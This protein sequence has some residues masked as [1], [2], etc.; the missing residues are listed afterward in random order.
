MLAMKAMFERRILL[1]IGLAFIIDSVVTAPAHAQRADDPVAFV[2]SLGQQAIA[3]L[4]DTTLS[5]SDRTR[6]FRELLLDHFDM[7]SIGRL[8]M[9]RHWRRVSAAQKDV[10]EPLFEDYVIATYG[11]RLDAYSGEQLT[12][13]IAR[14]AN[15]K[16]MAVS[17]EITR[18]QGQSVDVD[19]MLHRRNDRW[20]VIDVIVEG[21]S[22]V[23]SQRSEFSTVI[24][25]RGGIDGLIENIQTR[26]DIVSAD[27][28]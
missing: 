14:Q 4:A 16:V 23:I 1:A 8:V 13:G 6:V 28:S 3:L 21:I 20:Y 24:N 15:D 22:M 17:S 11:S 12:V 26:I 5:V 9:G 25:Q 2:R 27:Q 19:W 7:K 18:Q 10:F